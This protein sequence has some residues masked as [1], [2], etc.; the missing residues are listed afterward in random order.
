MRVYARSDIRT[1]SQ[2][3]NFSC[4]QSAILGGV[5][6]PLSLT[7]SFGDIPSGWFRVQGLGFRV[8]G[9]GFRVQ[10]LGFRVQGLGFRVQVDGRGEIQPLKGT[11]SLEIHTGHTQKNA[12]SDQ[13]QRL[14]SP[15]SLKPW[16]FAQWQCELAT[17]VDPSHY[18]YRELILHVDDFKS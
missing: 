8:Q 4:R 6:Q 2:N 14:I 17:V 13:S 3:R 7:L 16:N 18:L 9:L 15:Q 10:G 11:H 1:Q 12:F 5:N